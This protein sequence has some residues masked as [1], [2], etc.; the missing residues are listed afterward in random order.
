MLCA[1]PSSHADL[2]LPPDNS[3][4]DSAGCGDGGGTGGRSFV[5]GGGGGGAKVGLGHVSIGISSESGLVDFGANLYV[6]KRNNK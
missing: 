4:C 1:S 6:E 2:L 5:G 3:S